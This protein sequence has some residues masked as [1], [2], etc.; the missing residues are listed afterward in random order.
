MIEQKKPQADQTDKTKHKTNFYL[1]IQRLTSLTPNQ[2]IIFAEI[3]SLV[4]I[5]GECFALNKHFMKK[6][7]ISQPT[8]S[9]TLH[10]LQV[11]DLIRIE[12]RR[13]QSGLYRRM[14]Y[15]TPRTFRLI[16]KGKR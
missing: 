8:V 15:L 14:I 12:E 16:Y 4:I 7:S 5:A 1:A 13:P 9:A 10:R 2:K 6:F 11:L 3:V